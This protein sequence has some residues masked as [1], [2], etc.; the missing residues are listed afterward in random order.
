M[1]ALRTVSLL[2]GLSLVMIVLTLPLVSAV[3][4]LGAGS[5]LLLKASQGRVSGLW[6]ELPGDVRRALPTTWFLGPASVA[7]GA[8]SVLN[9]AFL[10]GQATLAAGAFYAVNVSAL[11]IAVW[12]LAACVHELAEDPEV[13]RAELVRRATSRATRFGL[14]H[15]AVL[16]GAAL[17]VALVIYVPLVGVIFGPGLALYLGRVA[18][19]RP[20]TSLRPCR[21]DL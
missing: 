13:A 16:L 1:D 14:W 2:A 17:T 10:A 9:L 7:V 15:V 21:G 8:I 11:L 4:A 19:P 18:A 12:W 6:R 3:P 20:T 5:R